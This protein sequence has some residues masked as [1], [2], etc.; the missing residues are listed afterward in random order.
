[1]LIII[2]GDS[3]KEVKHERVEIKGPFSTLMQRAPRPNFL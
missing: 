2:N 3:K 1:M